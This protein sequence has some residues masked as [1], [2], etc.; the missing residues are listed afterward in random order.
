MPTNKKQ[1]TRWMTLPV[2]TA[3]VKITAQ[4]VYKLIE[5]QLKKEENRTQ[6]THVTEKIIYR[7]INDDWTPSW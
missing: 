6:K 2:P 7:S 5:S 1:R 4:N 3:P